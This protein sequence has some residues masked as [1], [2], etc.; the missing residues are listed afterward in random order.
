M[1]I[2]ILIISGPFKGNTVEVNC[3]VICDARPLDFNYGQECLPVRVGQNE[4]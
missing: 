1:D 3:F 4:I 2:Y